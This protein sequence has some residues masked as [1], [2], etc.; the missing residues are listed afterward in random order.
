[1]CYGLPCRGLP[2]RPSGSCSESSPVSSPGAIGV[3]PV[4]FT[5]SNSRWPRE[6]HSNSRTNAEKKQF[7]GYILDLD[8]AC[9][10]LICIYKH[11]CESEVPSPIMYFGQLLLQCAFTYDERGR[12][13]GMELFSHGILQFGRLE[14]KGA[15]VVSPWLWNDQGYVHGNT[16]SIGA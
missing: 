9:V 8:F 4:D 11:N 14:P 1:M 12:N 7:M 2:G 3:I 15:T 13:F 6:T 5:K 16:C 10:Y